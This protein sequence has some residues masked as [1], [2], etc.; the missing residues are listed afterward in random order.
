[1]ERVRIRICPSGEARSLVRCF[2]TTLL[3]TALCRH[4]ETGWLPLTSFKHSAQLPQLYQG[5]GLHNFY[6]QRGEG[7]GTRSAFWWQPPGWF[8]HLE[9]PDRLTTMRVSSRNN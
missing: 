2:W 6:H 4:A 8:A 5:V 7:D 3:P 9:S 1:M